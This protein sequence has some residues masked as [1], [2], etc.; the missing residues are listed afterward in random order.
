LRKGYARFSK[1]ILEFRHLKDTKVRKMKLK[2]HKI[3]KPG[4]ST[5]PTGLD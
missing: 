2:R 1:S 4:G 3:K 5:V